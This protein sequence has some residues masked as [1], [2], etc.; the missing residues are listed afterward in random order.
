MSGEGEVPQIKIEVLSPE[1]AE[2]NVRQEKIA[3]IFATLIPLLKSVS[4]ISIQIAS[5]HPLAISSNGTSLRKPFPTIPSWT[6]SPEMCAPS[7]ACHSGPVWLFDRSLSPTP[8]QDHLGVC[9][10]SC[11]PWCL[12]VVTSRREEWMGQGRYQDSMLVGESVGKSQEQSGS[13][14]GALGVVGSRVD[15]GRALW[16]GGWQVYQ[17]MPALGTETGGKE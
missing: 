3:S 16:G 5:I 14:W 8:D 6:G 10:L 15:D 7:R 11:S 9:G 17:Q 2:M 4:R 12:Q 1:Q 13:P